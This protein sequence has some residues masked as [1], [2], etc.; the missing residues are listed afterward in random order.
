[1]TFHDHWLKGDTR[2]DVEASLADAGISLLPTSVS[3]YDPIGVISRPTGEL[4]PEGNPVM[5]DLPGW[6]A[7]LRMRHALTADQ[8]D[9][10]APVLIPK[11]QH[12]ARVWA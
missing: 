12:P 7:N 5:E 11:P 6:H 8:A 9:A 2:L 1:M 10:L 3:S 4:D